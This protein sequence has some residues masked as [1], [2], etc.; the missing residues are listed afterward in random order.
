M[1]FTDAELASEW[2]RQDSFFKTARRRT[3]ILGDQKH[4]VESRE[5]EWDRLRIV[6]RFATL[7]HYDEAAA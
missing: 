3:E 7:P 6:E 4:L 1:R 2:W 5:R